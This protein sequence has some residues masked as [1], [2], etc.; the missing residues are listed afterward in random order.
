MSPHAFALRPGGRMCFANAPNFGHRPDDEAYRLVESDDAAA[1]LRQAER[2][3][4]PAFRYIDAED[5]KETLGTADDAVEAIES[6]EYDDVLDLLLFAERNEF[7]PR[8][9]VTEAIAARHREAAARRSGTDDGAQG[10]RHDDIAPE[11]QNADD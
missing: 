2:A 8:V 11:V 3:G 10:L 4:E 5:L 1:T 6:G 9:T 7:G